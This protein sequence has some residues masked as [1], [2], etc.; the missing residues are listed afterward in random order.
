MLALI[1][2]YFAQAFMEIRK[3]RPVRVAIER[4]VDSREKPAETAADAPVAEDEGKP[5]TLE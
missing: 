1:L 2:G 4:V 3:V 5:A